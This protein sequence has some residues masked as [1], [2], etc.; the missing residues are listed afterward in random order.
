MGP[1]S[2]QQVGFDGEGDGLLRDG[3]FRGDGDSGAERSPAA[4]AMV[5]RDGLGGQAG[6]GQG[7]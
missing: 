7:I 4:N 2:G 1:F 3:G 5:G 6:R